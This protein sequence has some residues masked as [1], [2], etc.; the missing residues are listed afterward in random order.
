[1]GQ[2]IKMPLLL[3]LFYRRKKLQLAAVDRNNNP[4]NISDTVSCPK[5]S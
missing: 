5:T 1:M 2:Q 4:N 3:D